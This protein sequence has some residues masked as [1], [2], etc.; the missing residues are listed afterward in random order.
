M[1]KCS[2]GV[3]ALF[4][5]VKRHVTGCKLVETLLPS[6]ETTFGSFS[7]GISGWLVVSFF[8]FFIDSRL[9]E[10]A[11]VFGALLFSATPTCAKRERRNVHF[12]FLF[13]SPLFHSV[14][15]D[16][17]VLF[18]SFRLF[19]LVDICVCSSPSSTLLLH[20]PLFVKSDSQSDSSVGGN[21]SCGKAKLW[22]KRKSARAQE[23]SENKRFVVVFFLFWLFR[24]V[25]WLKNF[26]L[27][28][29][30][31]DKAQR[32]FKWIIVAWIKSGFD[33]SLGALMECL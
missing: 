13:I 9:S 27:C 15:R 33:A 11:F 10:R 14:S 28:I 17:F 32:H 30:T 24:S 22:A 1:A 29:Q 6:E 8:L 3:K 20:I 5:Y 23:E 12:I 19:V 26:S 18:S 4:V 21:T 25:L 16:F 31:E 2:K 7:I